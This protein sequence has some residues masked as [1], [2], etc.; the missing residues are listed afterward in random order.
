ME[1]FEQSSTKRDN[2]QKNCFPVELMGLW[3]EEEG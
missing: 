2:L 1:Y 3:D